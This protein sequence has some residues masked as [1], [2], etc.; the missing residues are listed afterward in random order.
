MTS[1]FPRGD[2][3]QVEVAGLEHHWDAVRALT[4]NRPRDEDEIEREKS[5]KL[6]LVR[7]PNN[8]YDTNAIAVWSDK[9]GHVG[10][11]PKELAAELSPGLESLRELAAKE[12]RGDALDLYC[13]ADLY[14]EWNDWDP[15]LDDGD[16]NDPV[17]VTL[18]L[19]FALP[20]QPTSSRRADKA[21]T[22]E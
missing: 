7:E 19:C 21:P 20:L 6:R 9:H 22:K 18:T 16:K 10:Y 5:V 13:S 3:L 8:Q 17:E 15:D 4:G 12:L 11:V 14:A 1:T 2:D